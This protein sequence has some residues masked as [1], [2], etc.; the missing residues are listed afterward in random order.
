[1][2]TRRHTLRILLLAIVIVLGHGLREGGETLNLA[3]VIPLLDVPTQH[4]TP[5]SRKG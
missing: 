1:M 5:P 3:G 4:Q 2:K